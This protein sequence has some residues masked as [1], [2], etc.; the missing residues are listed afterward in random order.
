TSMKMD[1]SPKWLASR[2]RMRPAIASESARRDEMRMFGMPDSQNHPAAILSK[3]PLTEGGL[4]LAPP[5]WE[6]AARAAQPPSP[7]PEWTRPASKVG[8]PEGVSASPA[9]LQPPSSRP[10]QDVARLDIRPP[11]GVLAEPGDHRQRRERLAV[12]HDE[13]VVAEA[14]AD[15]RCLGARVLVGAG[16]QLEQEHR[17]VARDGG[18]GAV[19]HRPLA[20]FDVGLD[21]AHIAQVEGVERADI[22]LERLL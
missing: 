6:R 1:V 14:R 16:Q 19:E 8:A 17:P 2:S 12:L 15:R 20:A 13:R 18:A 22:D 10:K 7:C 4:S 11:R 9:T 5:Q 21:E 3:P